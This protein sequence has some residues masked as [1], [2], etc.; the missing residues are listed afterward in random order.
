M[1]GDLDLSFL[2]VTLDTDSLNCERKGEAERGRNAALGESKDL[3][4]ERFR[5]LEGIV[6]GLAAPAASTC[7]HWE[8]GLE[9]LG[10]TVCISLTKGRAFRASVL[11]GDLRNW[12]LSCFFSFPTS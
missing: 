10:N 8:H 4:L 3:D 12:Y 11:R 9:R 1:V 5:M 6:S 7:E 2:E